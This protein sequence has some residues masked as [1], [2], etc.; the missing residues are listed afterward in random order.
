MINGF[1]SHMTRY[2]EYKQCVVKSQHKL[3]AA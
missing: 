1:S 2:I 3:K